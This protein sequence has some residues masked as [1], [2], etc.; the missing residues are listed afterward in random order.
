MVD[1]T[2][3]IEELHKNINATLEAR[4]KAL[5]QVAALGEQAA[6]LRGKLAALM[7]QEQEEKALA[8]AAPEAHGG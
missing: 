5:H 2:N 3:K 1:R 4:D 7:E 8:K 6:F